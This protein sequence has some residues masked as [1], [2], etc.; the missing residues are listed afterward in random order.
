MTSPFSKAS[1]YVF[2][3][4][5]HPAHIRG[6]LLGPDGTGGGMFL[7]DI[8]FIHEA[9]T[10]RNALLRGDDWPFPDSDSDDS[11]DSDARAGGI[12]TLSVSCRSLDG[13]RMAGMDEVESRLMTVFVNAP[14]DDDDSDGDE[15]EG[16]GEDSSDDDSVMAHAVWLAGTERDWPDKVELASERYDKL[17][18]VLRL[19]R[20]NPQ[21]YFS[22]DFKHRFLKSAVTPVL[23]LFL[24]PVDTHVTSAYKWLRKT[25]RMCLRPWSYGV[26]QTE[27]DENYSR[28]RKQTQKTVD[29]KALYM[30]DLDTEYG[31]SGNTSTTVVTVGYDPDDYHGQGEV[32]DSEDDKGLFYFMDGGLDDR[33]ARRI[34]AQTWYKT[35]SKVFYKAWGSKHTSTF[36]PGSITPDR[37]VWSHE[38]QSP[39][40]ADGWTQ[41][42]VTE[43]VEDGYVTIDLEIPYRLIEEGTR[44]LRIKK[45]SVYLLARFIYADPDVDY[46][47]AK[48]MTVSEFPQLVDG[49]QVIG[50]GS[51]EY[52]TGELDIKTVND[53]F[54]IPL[55]GAQIVKLEEEWDWGNPGEMVEGTGI[56]GLAHTRPVPTVGVRFM[57]DIEGYVADVAACA[58][59]D[60]PSEVD[61]QS[62]LP[63][64]NTGVADPESPTQEEWE[65]EHPGD[66]PSQYQSG[67]AETIGT[68]SASIDIW[69]DKV[70][71]EVEPTSKVN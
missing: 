4:P 39:A 55:S 42:E 19:P 48:R 15:G 56:D 17:P 58:G 50:G 22:L 51:G 37:W 65:A 5:N 31:G 8:A 10:E 70:V 64:I 3:R 2:T 62:L 29:K 54:V 30:L 60:N 1:D 63:P 40:T 35:A 25:K 13:A 44:T 23:D 11:D 18:K 6:V 9:L 59:V 43:E 66:A 26:Q 27:K 67:Q 28:S 20:C 45:A 49:G 12:D 16:E 34:A 53:L 33:S 7:E 68:F 57:T 36:I 21:H 69:V 61:V 41:Y 14:P 38:Y 32:V 46:G 71:L 47:W 24:W 52:T